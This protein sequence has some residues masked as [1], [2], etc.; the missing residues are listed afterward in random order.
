MVGGIVSVLLLP[1][2]LVFRVLLQIR[3]LAF[4]LGIA[5]THPPAI[6]VVSVGNL[7]VGGTGKTPVSRWVVQRLEAAG[8]LPAV[9]LRG[10]GAD[11]V[12]LHRRWAPEVPVVAD[13]DRVAGVTAAAAAGAD[14]AVLD[15]AFQH[16]RIGR[17]LDIVLLAAEEPFPGPVLP[18]GAYREPASA[19]DRADV[20]VITRKRASE[21]Q[22]EVVER[23]L[24][25][26]GLKR[27]VVRMHLRPTG[28]RTLAEWG[29]DASSGH[30]D[31]QAVAVVN[32]LE[33]PIRVASGVGD[34]DSVVAAVR[35]LGLDVAGRAD[36]PDH[37]D[38]TGEDVARM[39]EQPGPLVVTEKDAIKLHVLAPDAKDIFVL[40]QEVVV[41]QG[42]DLLDRLLEG[43]PTPSGSDG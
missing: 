33:G 4:G 22:A 24:R 38:F 15:D 11:E 41:E 28:L 3:A 23:T 29:A 18:R 8:R 10:Y 39:R 42:T 26:R 13:A 34:P 16:R 19:L 40:E 7:S 17:D 31:D 2:S 6:P 5:R 25:R 1:V 20:I 35:A 27:P 14:I 12:A 30:P 37:H 21:E 36:F 43:L 32:S 9:V